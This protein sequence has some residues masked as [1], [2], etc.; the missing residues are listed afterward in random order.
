MSRRI[1]L[2]AIFILLISFSVSATNWCKTDHVLFQVY[3]PDGFN[4]NSIPD[5][6]YC[7]CSQVDGTTNE[8]HDIFSGWALGTLSL[9]SGDRIILHNSH[10]TGYTYDVPLNAF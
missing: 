3:Y 5:D 2:I 7:W 8:P 10:K 9:P 4:V 6:P 1:F